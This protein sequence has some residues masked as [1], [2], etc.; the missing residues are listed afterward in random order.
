M[1]V[2]FTDLKI[3]KLKEEVIKLSIELKAV[4]DSSMTYSS[5]S[6]RISP[7]LSK[8]SRV[9]R[10]IMKD[11]THDLVHKI[12]GALDEIDQLEK[13]KLEEKKNV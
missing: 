8:H 11:K 2:S 3:N 4:E 7:S 12:N 9:Y 1:A 6:N 13:E 5:V 10:K